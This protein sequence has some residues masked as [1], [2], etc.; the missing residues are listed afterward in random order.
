MLNF[1]MIVEDA[2]ELKTVTRPEIIAAMQGILIRT[3]VEKVVDVALNEVLDARAIAAGEYDL[4]DNVTPMVFSGE[5]DNEF[6]H[7]DEI[8]EQAALDIADAA[9][10]GF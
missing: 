7:D 6:A 1:V 3:D 10:H 9:K 5:P 4:R 8:E 2:G